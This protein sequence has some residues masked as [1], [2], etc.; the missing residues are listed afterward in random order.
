MSSCH[1]A[2]GDY[3]PGPYQVS[4]SAGQPSATLSIQTEND[5]IAELTE[6]FKVM[7]VSTSKPDL[8]NIGDP[9][10]S[11]VTIVDNDCEFVLNKPLTCSLTLIS[12]LII[13]FSAITCSKAPRN[14][15]VTEGEVANLTIVCS[16]SYDFEFTLDL[17]TMDGSAVG[18]C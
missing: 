2:P 12:P 18:E 4:F 16:G 3:V 7:I 17:D 11:Y 1:A 8:V 15:T 6:Y 13:P 14:A 5:N 9:D 10:T